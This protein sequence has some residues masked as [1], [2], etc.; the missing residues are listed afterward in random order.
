MAI[1]TEE[2]PESAS[3]RLF[4]VLWA[5]ALLFDRFVRGASTDMLGF[6][7]VLGALW[8][9]LRPGRPLRLLSLATLHL[10]WFVSI[11]AEKVYVHWYLDALVNLVLVLAGLSAARAHG[12]RFPMRSLMSRFAP[13]GRLIVLLAMFFAG[14]AKLNTSFLNAETSCAAALYDFQRDQLPFLPEAE[15]A[16]Q[17]A[18]YFAVVAELGAP[19]VLLVRPLRALGLLLA[20]GLFLL[21]GTNAQAELYEFTAAFLS[22]LSLFL[23]RPVV[24]ERIAWLRSLSWAKRVGSF[25]SARRV[26]RALT[27]GLGALFAFYLIYAGDRDPVAGY[28]RKLFS[29]ALYVLVV[30]GLGA[31]SLS[32]LRSGARTGASLKNLLLT[33]PACLLLVPL[34][35]AL[36]ESTVYLGYKHMPTFTM[37]SNLKLERGQSNH[38]LVQEPPAFESNRVVRVV[39]SKD[40]WL[41]PGRG[42]LWG[43]FAD[44]LSR[45]PGQAVTFEVDGRRETVDDT[46]RDPRFQRTS[47]AMALLTRAGDRH[48]WGKPFT[49][50]IGQGEK[51]CHHRVADLRAREERRAREREAARRS[52]WRRYFR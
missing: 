3:G 30:A 18:V 37:A 14:F 23:P 24:V 34:L 28:E 15:W 13:A 35:F 26:L 27:L 50:S 12:L 44:Y 17:A 25:W 40:R 52:G 8:V 51:R 48:A 31:L 42:V 7:I 1:V 38:L 5:T 10:I 6:G 33:G 29:R 11:V 46:N 22:L 2:Q 43:G 45:A 21:I 16:R 32:A 47:A 20:L 19:F 39:R 41:K 9:L 36:H 4:A 49:F